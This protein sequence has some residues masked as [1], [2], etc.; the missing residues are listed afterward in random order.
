MSI[1]IQ[2]P[3]PYDL[4]GD[5]V[6]VAGLAG[7]AFESNF[8]YEISE[9]HDEVSGNFMA[10][11]LGAHDQFQFAS[12]TS[13]AG[14]SLSRAFL[15]VYHQ[16]ARDG[17]ILDEVLVPILLGNRIWP[18]FKGYREY[19]VQAGDT[20]WSIATDQMGAGVNYHALAAANQPAVSDPDSISVG[21]VLRVPYRD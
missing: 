13:S 19:T 12:D 16:S 17:S 10:G 20:L 7:G 9:G 3:Q 1:T 15:R 11:Y 8:S 4:V 18:G 14:F 6:Q 2:Q 5:I 21:Q